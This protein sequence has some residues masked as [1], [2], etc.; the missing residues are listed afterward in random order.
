MKALTWQAKRSVQVDEVPDP[1]IEFPTDAIVKITSSAICGSDLHLYEIFGPFIDEGGGT[2]G[3][4]LTP[5]AT[6]VLTTSA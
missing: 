5:S 3:L 4:L 6:R 1:R 2:A